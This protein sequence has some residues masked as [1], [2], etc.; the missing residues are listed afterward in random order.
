MNTGCVRWQLAVG[1]P[2]KEATLCRELGIS[3]P[4]ARILVSR[5][6]DTLESAAE[7]FDFSWEKVP[8]LGFWQI[9]SRP[10]AT[11]ESCGKAGADY[12][13]R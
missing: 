3:A 8:P 9:W 2:A 5:G 1:D 7:F 11:G 12:H 6:I 13:L 4:L 10:R